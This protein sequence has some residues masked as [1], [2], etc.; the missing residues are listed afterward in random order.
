VKRKPRH[1][2][3]HNQTGAGFAGEQ[4]FETCCYCGLVCVCHWEDRSGPLGGHGPYVEA[5][6]MPLKVRVGMRAGDDVWC[7]GSTRSDRKD[8]ADVD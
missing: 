4:W 7:E 6:L 1:H 2:C 3:W 8:A 5:T